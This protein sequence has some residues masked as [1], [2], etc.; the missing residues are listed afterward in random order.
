MQ[1]GPLSP[2]KGNWVDREDDES[3]NHLAHDPDAPA[4]PVMG[5]PIVAAEFETPMS[6]PS[7]QKDEPQDAVATVV[8]TQAS[9]DAATPAAVPV[10]SMET[11]QQT[12]STAAAAVPEEPAAVPEP[13][14]PSTPS[15]PS[16]ARY[17]ASIDVG[18]GNYIP[19]GSGAAPATKIDFEAEKG[20]IEEQFA[21]LE[22]ALDGGSMERERIEQEFEALT[23][24][25]D[26]LRRLEE[27]EKAA[28]RNQT[29]RPTSLA[30]VRVTHKRR[31]ST[32]C[33]MAVVHWKKVSK[34][35]FAGYKEALL[36]KYGQGDH[37][38]KSIQKIPN[39]ILITAPNAVVMEAILNDPS[40]DPRPEPYIMPGT[41]P[42]KPS[43]PPPPTKLEPMAPIEGLPR[44]QVN[45]LPPLQVAL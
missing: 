32:T 2:A 35:Q 25:A 27:A 9:A 29:S 24:K 17:A 3:S 12:E 33:S 19:V 16:K 26:T 44:L 43:A 23:H 31:N 11:R 13:S 30:P 8:A 22:R 38:V 41:S 34:E 36:A 5:A 7:P 40:L 28:A 6:P 42:A 10:A 1:Q 18:N 39:R 20:K 14:T 15:T 45:T 37:A 21:A 4:P